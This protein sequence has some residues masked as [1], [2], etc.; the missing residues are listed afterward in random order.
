MDVPLSS[1]REFCTDFETARVEKIILSSALFHTR[2]ENFFI[3]RF[4]L[5]Q[6]V[7]LNSRAKTDKTAHSCL[8]TFLV[9]ILE[10]PSATTSSKAAR[11]NASI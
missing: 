1:K 11:R 5:L 10:T 2:D 3:F 7:D 6:Y 9:T 8:L 4:L